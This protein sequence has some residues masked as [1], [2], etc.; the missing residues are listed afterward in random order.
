MRIAL[1][2]ASLRA[3]VVLGMSLALGLTLG[4]SRDPNKQKQ[5]YLESGKRYADEGKLKEATI[6]FANALRVAEHLQARL[7]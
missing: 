3:S 5:K 4:C 1:V 2:S 7:A 6:K